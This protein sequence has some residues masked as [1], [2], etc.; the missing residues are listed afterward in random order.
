[1]T[2]LGRVSRLPLIS[3]DDLNDAAAL[4]QRVDR[5]YILDEDQLSAM[6]Q[7]LATRLAA[8]E[9]ANQRSFSY[10]SVYFDT[11]TFDSY[12]SAAYKRRNRFKVRTR[13]YLDSG[14][15]MLEVKTRGARNATVKTRQ[16]YGF[17]NRALVVP[18]SYGFI[19]AA[20]GRVGLGAQLSPVLMTEYERI[21]LV[22]LDDIARLTID[23]DLRCTD[24]AN[25]EMQLDG[26]YVVE[27]KSAGPPSS[28]D[29]WLWSSSIRPTKISKFGT[30]L[31]VLNPEL[32]SNKW[33]RTINQHFA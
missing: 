5:K 22:D 32:P 28:A 25:N 33:H 6:I 24:W 20:T 19:D 16:E 12:L 15:T 2:A 26:K 4:Q 11:P 30:S 8:L 14:S 7:A 23:A 21:T 10:E 27:T 3:L 31:A 13:S 17:R 18:E 1:M 9:I 29:R